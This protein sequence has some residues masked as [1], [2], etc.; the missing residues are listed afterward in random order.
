MNLSG[1]STRAG[2]RKE[3]AMGGINCPPPEGV[4]DRIMY[5]RDLTSYCGPLFSGISQFWAAQALTE[6][7]I[8]DGGVSLSAVTDAL[9]GSATQLALAQSRFGTFASVHNE[10]RVD[11]TDAL[12]TAIDAVTNVGLELEMLSGD[13]NVQAQLW[14]TVVTETMARAATLIGSLGSLQVQFALTALRQ[15]VSAPA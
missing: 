1:I 2:T 7:V 14:T 11:L 6:Q 12:G 15:P 13:G 8:M 10:T 3:T 4:H 9:N 5:E